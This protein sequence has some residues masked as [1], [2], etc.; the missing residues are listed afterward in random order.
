MS[1]SDTLRKVA[2][3]SEALRGELKTAADN[4]WAISQTLAIIEQK[5]W[6]LAVKLDQD[7]YRRIAREESA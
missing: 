6:K 4:L 2:G 5:L 1:D 3:D 7:E